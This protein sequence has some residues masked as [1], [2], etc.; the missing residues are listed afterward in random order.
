[1]ELGS[2]FFFF[3]LLLATKLT[4]LESG[5]ISHLWKSLKDE[6]L[7]CWILSPSQV[8][9]EG[10]P[11]LRRF[12][13]TLNSVEFWLNKANCTFKPTP[14]DVTGTASANGTYDGFLGIIQRHEADLAYLAVRP[15]SLPFEPGK[16]TPPIQSA[17]ITIM[18]RKPNVTRVHRDLTS[19]LAL[20]ICVYAYVFTS[21]FFIVPLVMVFSE[22]RGIERFNPVTITRKYFMSCYRVFNLMVD[23][24]QFYQTTLPSYILALS[25]SIFA[26]VAIFG[27]LVNTVGADLVIKKEPSVI[28]SLDDLLNDR[29]KPVLPKRLFAY[30]LAQVSPPGSK[31]NQLWQRMRR[32]GLNET[33]WDI[34]LTNTA[35]VLPRFLELFDR[36]NQSRAAILVPHA[37]V[38]WVHTVACFMKQYKVM[39]EIGQ[40]LH[41]A[42]ELFAPGMITG[43]MSNRIH[44]YAEK[45]I[46]YL[47]RTFLET[48]MTGGI[49][50]SLIPILPEIAPEANLKY[51]SSVLMCLEKNKKREGEAFRPFSATDMLKLFEIWAFLSSSWSIVV[52]SEVIFVRYLLSFF[53]HRRKRS[54]GRKK[55]Q[56]IFLAKTAGPRVQGG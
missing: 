25:I 47:L 2:N 4:P 49:I 51:D 27:V 50:Q 46:T 44:V 39:N 26:L 10:M 38:P 1:M 42:S 36:M 11:L 14:Y 23:Q 40:S 53:T 28:N 37:S 29:M 30:H 22:S 21:C 45:I 18:S 16:P 20:D 54:T 32:E 41:V 17:D 24:E 15:D 35:N 12:K 43:I 3:A 19:F 34:D 52:L 5:K 55:I 6:N 13:D 33:T 56:P 9:I 7:R 8:K 48:G 31:L